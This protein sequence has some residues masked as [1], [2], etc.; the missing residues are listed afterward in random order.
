MSGS[1]S[2]PSPRLDASEDSYSSVEHPVLILGGSGRGLLSE[3]RRC[4]KAAR[5]SWRKEREREERTRARSSVA[6]ETQ[7][8]GP[9]LAPLLEPSHLT[10]P[11]PRPHT[12]K[13]LRL[14]ARR[15]LPPRALLS[16]RHQSTQPLP[17]L[18]RAEPVVVPLPAAAAGPPPPLP[19][20]GP[21]PQ[22]AAAPEPTPRVAPELPSKPPTPP[23]APPAP[24][25][26]SRPS[27]PGFGKRLR[28]L[29]L[30]SALFLGTGALLVY[31]Y[32]SRAGVHRCVAPS[33]VEH[34]GLAELTAC[35]PH[36]H[37]WLVQPALMALT[38]DDPELA[39]ELAV[40]ILAKNIGP[41]DCGVD[42]ERL[43]LEV[44]SLPFSL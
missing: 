20:P 37:S 2:P 30:S 33:R 35:C 14:G 11:P 38:K 28:S 24:P 12:L 3:L 27:G 42:D 43:A 34:T 5:R 4:R 22:P 41:V 7:Y 31:A 8:S 18:P 36:D 9:K 26:P 15:A 21:G 1:M 16:L 29:L 44:S 23:P 40:K 6:C 25:L 13:M 10:E 19:P 17:P 32:D 39:H